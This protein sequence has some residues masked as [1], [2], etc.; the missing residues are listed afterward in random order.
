[1]VTI[2]KFEDLIIWQDSK[3]LTLS[4]Y[5]HFRRIKDFGLKDQIQR[6]TVSVM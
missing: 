5:E 6:A 3:S 2:K 4:I 1:M